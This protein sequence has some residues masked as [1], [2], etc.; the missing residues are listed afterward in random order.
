MTAKS[1]ID[2]MWEL[3]GDLMR[4]HVEVR[5]GGTRFGSKTGELRGL[6]VEDVT[7]VLGFNPEQIDP[8][9]GKMSNRW[10]FQASVDGGPWVNCGIWE[11]S[12]FQFSTGGLASVFKALFGE[13]Y[14][15]PPWAGSEGEL[16]GYRP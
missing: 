6:S 10:R 8:Y 12:G 16:P 2:E 9:Y 11:Y 1:I 3:S 4:P 13:N 5:P 15:I 14:K 7:G